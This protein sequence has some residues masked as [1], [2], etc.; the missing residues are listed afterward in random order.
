MGAVLCSLAAAAGPIICK[1]ASAMDGRIRVAAPLTLANQLPLPMIIKGGW[2]G[3]PVRC[4][5]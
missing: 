1:L 3:F 4:T 2:S 5:M